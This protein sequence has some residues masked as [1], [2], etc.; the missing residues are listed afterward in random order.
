MEHNRERD[1]GF[2]NIKRYEMNSTDSDGDIIQELQLV[3]KYYN[4]VLVIQCCKVCLVKFEL[5]ELD[6]YR[7]PTISFNNFVIP[8]VRSKF[9]IDL[10]DGRPQI[11][12]NIYNID[13]SGNDSNSWITQYL[14]EYKCSRTNPGRIALHRYKSITE[15]VT[16]RFGYFAVGFW[17]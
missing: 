16:V 6:G 13:R 8:F 7:S 4:G 2:C 5:K 14:P 9:D 1:N 17:K 3:K 15:K 12:Y 10:L 11:F